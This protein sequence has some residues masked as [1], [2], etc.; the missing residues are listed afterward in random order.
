MNDDF[1]AGASKGSPG[2]PGLKA[3]DAA[4]IHLD[5]GAQTPIVSTADGTEDAFRLTDSSD[6]SAVLAAGSPALELLDGNR[7]DTDPPCN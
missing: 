4:G 3:T 1:E 5:H 6:Q 7:E 2:R